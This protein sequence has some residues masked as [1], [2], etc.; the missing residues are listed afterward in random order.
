MDIRPISDHPRRVLVSGA[1]GAIGKAI[2]L[3]VAAQ[4]GYA[5]TLLAR[6][7]N[8]AICTAEEIRRS[9]GNPDV[10]YEI[11]DLGRKAEIDALAAHWQG[12]LH[13]LINNAAITPRW[14]QETPEGIE[15]QFAVN[16]LGYF[17]MIRAFSD[18]LKRS[19]PARVVNVAS[20]WAGEL[21][22]DDLQFIRRPYHNGSAYRQSKQA[23]RMLTAAFAGQLGAHGVCV[24]ACQPGDVNSRLSNDLGF[25]GHETPAQ[26]ADTP[27]WLALSETSGQA[28]GKYFEART[29]VHDRFT[30]DHSAVEKLYR[31][32]ELFG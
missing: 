23:D 14:R 2:A 27:V 21:D 13:V 16:V 15:M 24:N 19:A 10:D 18:I 30:D 17:W 7:E 32:C 22:L 6:D 8:K 20:Y 5:V 3:G 31:T 12:A 9:T 26:G 4:P 25:G 28:N 11:V 1:T 29:A